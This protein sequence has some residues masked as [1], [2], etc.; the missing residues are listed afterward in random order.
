MSKSDI[1]SFLVKPIHHKSNRYVIKLL[2][3]LISYL[4]VWSK[5]IL[6]VKL[7]LSIYLSIYIFY[8]LICIHIFRA[9]GYWQRLNLWFLFDYLISILEF[10]FMTIYFGFLTSRHQ[11]H[12][13]IFMYVLYTIAQS[14]LWPDVIKLDHITFRESYPKSTHKSFN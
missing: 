9:I 11:V 6:L 8:N 2:R 7:F 3:L 10:N 14:N 13:Y 1:W 12:L 5:L 4:K